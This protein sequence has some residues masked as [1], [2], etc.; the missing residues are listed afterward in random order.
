[1]DRTDEAE[2]LLR[3]AGDGAEQLALREWVDLAETWLITRT[4]RRCSGNRSA[5][6]RALGIGRRTLYAKM[7]KLGIEPRW[8]VA[9]KSSDRPAGDDLAAFPRVAAGRD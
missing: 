8:Q 7:E 2:R 1:M 3:A 9:G 4:L 5:A 6:A